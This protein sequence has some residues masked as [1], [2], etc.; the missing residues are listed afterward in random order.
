[1]CETTPDAMLL[2][3]TMGGTLVRVISASRRTDIPALYAPWF[4]NRVRDGY[5]HWVN[6]FGGQVYRVSLLPEDVVAIV[7]WTRHSAPLHRHL[8]E[9]EERGLTSY[10]HF[11]ITGYPRWLEPQAPKLESALESFRELSGRLGPSRVIWRYD[12]IILSDRTPAVYH[13]ER[14]AAL[15]A[16][17]RGLTTSCYF[18]FATFYG[19]T[20]RNLGKA[21]QAEGATIVQPSPNGTGLLASELAVVAASNGMTLKVCSCDDLVGGGV[22]RGSC[23]DREILQELRSEDLDLS[24]MKASPTREDCGCC[25]ATDIGAFDTCTFGCSYCYA[26]TSHRAAV[27]RRG[28][29]DPEDTLLWRPSTLTGVDLNSIAREQAEPKSRI[30]PRGLFGGDVGR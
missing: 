14:F 15:A 12:P 26:N 10:F 8:A 18:S 3:C 21:A 29:H 23:I 11:T 17:L 1:V 25:E 16:R 19:K 24:G 2:A 27:D 5:C 7:F 20:Q 6:P 28:R 4:M 30:E 13:R 22:E 9:L